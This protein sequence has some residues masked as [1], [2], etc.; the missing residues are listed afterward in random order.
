MCPHNAA[1]CQGLSTA[2]LQDESG[3]LQPHTQSSSAGVQQ[4]R[5]LV[6]S[7]LLVSP[8]KEPCRLCAMVED[9]PFA[10]SRVQAKC[11]RIVVLQYSTQRGVSVCRCLVQAAYYVSMKM[12]LASSGSGPGRAV[13]PQ[14][15]AHLHVKH[16]QCGWAEG[17]C[18]R[19]LQDACCQ[20]AD[21]H[22]FGSVQELEET[23][24][25]RR[26]TAQ[27]CGCG[28]VAK[29]DQRPNKGRVLLQVQDSLLTMRSPSVLHN[30]ELHSKPLMNTGS[31]QCCTQSSR[32]A[33][34]NP[35]HTTG[36]QHARLSGW[37][38][39]LLRL[40]V[41]QSISSQAPCAQ[42]LTLGIVAPVL[43][44]DVAQVFR[45]PHSCSTASAKAAR[46]KRAATAWYAA[47]LS[48]LRSAHICQGVGAEWKVSC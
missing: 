46:R 43:A 3:L 7:H 20:A 18:Q 1:G 11:I 22:L 42:A 25:L 15:P 47:C 38:G 27:L 40:L 2:R 13:L 8:R 6:D 45:I 41:R 5:A 19:S 21:S 35:G 4:C 29:I 17:L 30:T 28:G 32:H 23:A 10:T 44:C 14:Y 12:V 33:G 26:V 36:V 39:C 24:A 34:R 16:K 9:S 48:L 31:S 37:Y